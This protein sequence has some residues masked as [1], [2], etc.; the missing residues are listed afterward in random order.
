MEKDIEIYS[1]AKKLTI[2]TREKKT[3]ELAKKIHLKS[4]VILIPDIVLY[5]KKS[6]P[7]KNKKGILLC[8]RNDVESKFSKEQKKEI[9]NI[10]RKYNSSIKYTD[11]VINTYVRPNERK[12]QLGKKI[13]E[14]KKAELIITDRLH[15][16]IF[17]RIANT[18]CI[19]IGNYN[20]KVKG[21]YE[22]I[23]NEKNI[24]Y[25]EN[26]EEIEKNIKELIKAENKDKDENIVEKFDILKKYITEGSRII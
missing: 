14:F 16:M 7:Y 15:G 4:K 19:A 24:I 9:E 1:K 10:A 13:K 11:T 22:W 5:L 21:V 26:I 3:Y 25:V 6:K 2:C 23:K 8:I 17:A 18:K 20:Y 12:S